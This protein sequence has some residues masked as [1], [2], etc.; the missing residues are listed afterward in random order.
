MPEDFSSN[1][2][3][4]VWWVCEKGHEWQAQINSRSRGTGC[5]I[6]AGKKVLAGYNDLATKRPDIAEQWH[7]TK[8]GELTAQD[9]TAGSEKKVWWV[10]SKCGYEW[11]AQINNRTSTKYALCPMCRK[12]KINK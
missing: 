12:K 11:E 5:P 7:P 2:N 4:Q 3:K 6:C 1:S 8:N 9:F 10:C